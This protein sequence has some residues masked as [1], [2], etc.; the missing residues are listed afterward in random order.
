MRKD[1]GS[2]LVNLPANQINRLQFV[3]KSAARTFT[4]SHYKD[5]VGESRDRPN[6]AL[7]VLRSDL[8]VFSHSNRFVA[9]QTS[10][11]EIDTENTVGVENT[12]FVSQSAAGHCMVP[13]SKLFEMTTY[14]LDSSAWIKH[15][16]ARSLAALDSVSTK[17]V[18]I[19][20][21]LHGHIKA[22]TVLM[23]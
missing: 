18:I 19:S 15:I 12:V 2:L 4:R 23:T 21:N 8:Q 22:S 17:L 9:L 13:R 6:L 5:K 10:D 14:F 20:Y 11:I 3:N 7:N 16:G 1:T